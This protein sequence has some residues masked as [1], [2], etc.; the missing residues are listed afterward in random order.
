MLTENKRTNVGFKHG[1]GHDQLRWEEAGSK[2][3]SPLI[4]TY[5]V[6]RSEPLDDQ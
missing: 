5:T 1:V 2:D 4:A 3:C 6:W